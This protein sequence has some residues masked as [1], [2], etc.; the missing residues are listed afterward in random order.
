MMSEAR[1]SLAGEKA[2]F[3]QAA[4]SWRAVGRHVELADRAGGALVDDPVVP[5]GDGSR[6][7]RTL[8]ATAVVGHHEI[9]RQVAV[10]AHVHDV[11]GLGVEV[12]AG[13][14]PRQP[15]RDVGRLPVL[16]RE[17]VAGDGHPGV[18]RRSRGRGDDARIT[19]IRLVARRPGR[20][21]SRCPC[22]HA[23]RRGHAHGT[24]SRE[25]ATGSR[26]ATSGGCPPTMAA[27]R[28]SATSIFGRR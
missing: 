1:S 8:A 15:Q 14:S 18:R 7:G 10:A 2:T 13:R 19:R 24:A 9:S 23:R 28:P 6:V 5:G 3:P 22:V 12:A 21:R 11:V 20:L 25:T 27:D 26:T 4:L 17:P 16:V